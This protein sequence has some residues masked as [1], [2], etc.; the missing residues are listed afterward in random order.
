MLPTNSMESNR[1]KQILT[2]ALD[3]NDKTPRFIDDV[4]NGSS[5]N[6]VCPQC[7]N[8]LI[9]VNGVPNGE[10]RAHHFR[11]DPG[12]KC[13]CSDETLLHI[14]AKEVL[15]EKKIIMLPEDRNGARQLPFD[16]VESETLDPL[17]RLRPDCIC[18]Y[19]D[20]E[21]WVEFKR[22]HEVDRKKEAKICK[23]KINCIEIDINQCEYDKS[24]MLDFLINTSS[25]R[26]W[27]FNAETQESRSSRRSNGL[28]S[29]NCYIKRHLAYDEMANLVNLLQL[30]PN[31]DLRNHQ[32][33]CL[34]CRRQL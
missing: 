17:T 11:H 14:M 2:F 15:S 34:N 24:A 16:Y 19:G 3:A 12:S 31:Y 26:E 30:P 7:G 22:T 18:H 4:P 8:N 5:C 13:T 27:V 21:L 29:M 20:K 33:Y 10:G 28:N 32:Y 25:C 9:A 23:A 6:C 1:I